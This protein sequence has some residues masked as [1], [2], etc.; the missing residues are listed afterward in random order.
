MKLASERSVRQTTTQSRSVG[1]SRGPFSSVESNQPRIEARLTE[2]AAFVLELLENALKQA[3]CDSEEA[4]DQITRLVNQRRAFESWEWVGGNSRI[5]LDVEAFAQVMSQEKDEGIDQGG[6]RNRP[7]G[8]LLRELG[9]TLPAT[10]KTASV[11]VPCRRRAESDP[12]HSLG[13][14]SE[15]RE[16]DCPHSRTTAGSTSLRPP[17]RGSSR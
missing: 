9:L 4:R 17:R 16:D 10:T 2:L 8:V 1:H 13:G 12:S 6:Q 14:R 3:E 7:R 11:S 5:C 15:S